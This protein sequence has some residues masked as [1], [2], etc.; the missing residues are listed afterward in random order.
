MTNESNQWFGHGGQNINSMEDALAITT[1]QVAAVSFGRSA[2]NEIAAVANK[3]AAAC[4]EI[5]GSG[6]VSV[7]RAMKVKQVSERMSDFYDEL[8]TD[9]L[10]NLAPAIAACLEENP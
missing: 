7:A 10:G 9:L 2:M 5:F 8:V 4:L 3:R 6:H 1:S